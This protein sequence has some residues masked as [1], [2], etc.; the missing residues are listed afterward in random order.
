MARQRGSHIVLK[1]EIEGKT[2]GTSV[3]N[4]KELKVGTLKNV[5]ELA[6]VEE[7]KFAEYQ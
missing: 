7:E 1:K 6:K 4:H 5:L 3:P 2:T